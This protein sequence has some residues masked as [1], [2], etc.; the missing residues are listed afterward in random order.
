MHLTELLAE[1]PSLSVVS[2]AT[3][4]T[5]TQVTSDSRAIQAGGLF[6]AL[7]GHQTDGHNFIGDAITNGASIIVIDGRKIKTD[8]HVSVLA[9]ADSQADYARLCSKIYP[10]RPAILTAVTGTNGKTSVCEYL[11]QI[12]SRATWPSAPIGTLGVNSNIE[13]L[14]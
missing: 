7:K 6:F 11:R 8:E 2:G 12:W 13:S 5:V 1:Y 9:S 3:D 4:K 10:N 14:N